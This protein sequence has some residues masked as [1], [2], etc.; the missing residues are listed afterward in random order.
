MGF[1]DRLSQKDAVADDDYAYEGEEYDDFSDEEYYEES[2]NADI[3]PIRPVGSTEV[4]RI[5]TMWVADYQEIKEFAVDFRAGCP[6]ILNL[7]KASDAER[8]RIVDF[9]LGL[10]FGLEGVFSR[11]SEDVFLLTPCAVKIDSRGLN[12]EHDF[13]R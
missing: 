8:A 2:E 1:L 3:S 6:V 5:V 12:N 11:I 10:C 7:S 9:A 13:A 4:S